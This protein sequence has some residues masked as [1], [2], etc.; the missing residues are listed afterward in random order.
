VSVRTLQMQEVQSEGKLPWLYWTIIFQSV[1]WPLL[2]VDG[3]SI[4]ISVTCITSYPETD[5]QAGYQPASCFLSVSEKLCVRNC[6]LSTRGMDIV[7]ISSETMN[8]G[9]I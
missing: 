9:S 8:L 4:S 3:S 2:E 7:V 5:E 6:N 1:Q